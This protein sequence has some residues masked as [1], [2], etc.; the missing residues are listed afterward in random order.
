MASTRHVGQ[1]LVRPAWHW[2]DHHE[3]RAGD[4]AR[5]GLPHNLVSRWHH[6]RRS[7]RHTPV[8]SA[9]VTVK[10]FCCSLVGIAVLVFGLVRLSILGGQTAHGNDRQRPAS[11]RSFAEASATSRKRTGMIRVVSV[12][13]GTG[14]STLL[15]GLKTIEEFDITAIV[16]VADDG[17]STG[18]I[19]KNTKCRRRAI[20]ATA[21]SRWPEDESIVTRLF[22]Y[23]FDR[24]GFGTVRPFVRQ[25]LHHRFE[26]GHRQ[27]RRSR[28]RIGEG[29]GNPRSGV[30]LDPRFSRSLRRAGRWPYH[31][32]RIRTSDTA[33]AASASS[34]SSEPMA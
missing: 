29:A 9:S 30:P 20:S 17:G 15:R 22:D 19:R 24:E 14:L 23:R 28:H 16:T 8:S 21:S 10:A 18:R 33:T 12:G 34:I 7:K 6:R 11:D 2:R 27:F 25:S 32:R 4:G 1:T 31:L 3:S 5:L 13:G 26:P